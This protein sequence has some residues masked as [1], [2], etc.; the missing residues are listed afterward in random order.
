MTMAE[1]NAKKEKKPSRIKKFFRDYKS[2][3]KKIVW[4]T[5]S[6]TLKLSAV[7]LVAIVIAGVAIF[8][9]DTGFST[10]FSALGNL[11]G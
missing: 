2:E 8:L 5:R 10:L 6:E 3:F 7:V 4:P 9:L 1:E 11:V